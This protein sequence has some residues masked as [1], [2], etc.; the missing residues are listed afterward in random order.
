M[1]QGFEIL[2]IYNQRINLFSIIKPKRMKRIITLGLISILT[3]QFNHILAQGCI[4]VR[5]MSCATG[6]VNH[7]NADGTLSA[8]QKGDIQFTAGYRYLHS[9]K[10]FVG[11]V[12]QT[13]RVTEGTNVI[14]TTHSLDF[15][16]TYALN[17]RLMLNVSLPYNDNTRS[18]L[19]EHYGNTA[20]AN[21]N[22]QRFS[23]GSKGV[24]DLRVSASYWLI[25]PSKMPK[26][27]I[28]L[29]VGVKAPT[30]DPNAKDYFHKLDKS[31]KEYLALKTVDQSIQL[32]DGSWGMNVEVQGYHSLFKN[33]A[34]YFNGFYL[35]SPKNV[36]PLTTFSISDQYAGRLG[37]NY[38]I[39]SSLGISLGGRIEGLPAID[40]IGKSEGFRRPGYIISLEPGINYPLGHH[41]FG[42]NLPVALVRNRIKSWQDLQDPAGLKHG[43]AAFADYFV[44]ATYSY[45]F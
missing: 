5:H 19:Y 28:S 1:A 37:I 29:G 40:L 20:E 43:D 33:A 3:L 32:G 27:N 30:G 22:H 8:M 25:N 16:F 42:F 2:M 26:G 17:N 10:H 11:T 15:G 23:T 14:N 12:E 36:N 39:L 34:I 45:R 35:S 41:S 18:S 38:S 13:Q 9:Y 31:Q 44:S 21:P 6:G 7:I 24:G 4:A